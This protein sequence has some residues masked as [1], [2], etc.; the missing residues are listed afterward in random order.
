[1]EQKCEIRLAGSGGQGVIL[2]SII[3]AEAALLSGREVA[4]SQSYGPEARGGACKAEV[5]VDK[6]SIIYPKV[7][8]ANFLLAL[9]QQAL[10]TYCEDTAEDAMILADASLKVPVNVGGRTIKQAAILS[11]AIDK[12]GKAMTA[13][14]VAVGVVNQL[15]KIADPV[16]LERAVMMHVPPKTAELN[17]RAL[18]EGV[19]LAS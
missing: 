12:I 16:I 6:N 13:N 1:M 19:L 4:Q 8:K 14:I 15:L 7:R 18:H 17:M 10:D 9:T 3:L 11:T 2:A 5:V